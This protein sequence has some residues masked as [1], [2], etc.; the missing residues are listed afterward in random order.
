MERFIVLALI[1]VILSVQL[2]PVPNSVRF[3]I[4]VKVDAFVRPAQL[5]MD[6]MNA[7]HKTSAYAILIK[8]KLLQ[9]KQLKRIVKLGNFLFFIF[10][11][12]N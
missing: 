9:V 4:I 5:I 6:L 1:H 8:S 3:Q 7:F 10:L 2:Y 11:R 12:L